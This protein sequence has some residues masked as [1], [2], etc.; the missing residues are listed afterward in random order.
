VRER[1]VAVLGPRA[2]ERTPAPAGACPD[3]VELFSRHMEDEISG[4]VCAEMEAHVQRC[5]RCQR[6]CDSLRASLRLC[7]A[8]GDDE[9]PP[10]IA[11]SVRTALRRVLSSAARPPA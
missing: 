11:Q 5:D 3:V 10:A 9:V 1:L 6:L 2:P 4:A 7:R 8:A